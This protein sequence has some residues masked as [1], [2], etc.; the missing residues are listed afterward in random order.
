MTRLAQQG[1]KFAYIFKD[2]YDSDTI[3]EL[4]LNALSGQDRMRVEFL[5]A[6]NS[7]LE[8]G[9][10]F[11][12]AQA[13]REREEVKEGRHWEGEGNLNN[14]NETYTMAGRRISAEDHA[15][16]ARD[17]ADTESGATDA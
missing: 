17:E 2:G 9:F 7:S 12:L 1:T 5:Q 8:S 16:V 6:A 4:G 13:K 14:I 15:Q 11:I 10:T 3:Q